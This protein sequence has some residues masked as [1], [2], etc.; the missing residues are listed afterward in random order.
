MRWEDDLDR[1]LDERLDRE[2]EVDRKKGIDPNPVSL[3]LYDNSMNEIGVVSGTGW[4]RRSGSDIIVTGDFIKSSAYKIS[5]ASYGKVHQFR[6]Q[7]ASVG[8]IDILN[9]DSL[10]LKKCRPFNHTS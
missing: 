3:T 4:Q 9:A 2:D 8:D 7:P 10:T 5:K 6:D 1:Q